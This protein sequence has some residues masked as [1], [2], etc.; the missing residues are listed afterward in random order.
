MEM[1]L[2][3]LGERSIIAMIR[4]QYGYEWADDD[5]A[6]IDNGNKYMLI[7]TDSISE[8]SHM[9]K[10]ASFYSV[11]YFFAALN[12]SDIAAMGGTPKYFMT[13]FTLPRSMK[14]G[15]LIQLEKGMKACLDR[16]G[17][18]LIGGDLKQDTTINLSGTA[19]GD[20]I[21]GK[22]LRRNGVKKNDVL[23]VT[24]RLGKNA[25]AY[26]MWK[27]TGKRRWAELLIDIEPRIREGRLL[28]DYGASS[29]IDLSDGVFSA[30]SQLSRINRL[31]FEIDY[32]KVPVHNLAKKVGKELGLDIEDLALGFGGE[33]E[34]LF[35]IQGNRLA[36]LK[37]AGRRIGIEISEIGIAKGRKCVLIKDGKAKEI[38][39]RGYEHFTR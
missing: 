2:G 29:A 8:K 19:I 26:R 10:G 25:A 16:Y 5:A 33:Y 38:R 14:A 18:K 32:S 34:L 30:V 11:G 13:A 22:I 3:G 36:K 6:V 20:V 4:K 23:C 27:R 9:P 28:S 1:I 7:T 12:L 35:T 31:G 15:D 21:K 24:G 37:L 39:S 17:V